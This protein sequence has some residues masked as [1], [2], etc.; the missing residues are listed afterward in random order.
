MSE[1]KQLKTS[2]GYFDVV[3]NVLVDENTFSLNQ[4]GKNNANWISNIFNPKVDAG[5]G[6][7]MF[8][9]FNSGFDKVNGKTIYAISESDSS[10][11]IPF[12]DRKND[13]LLKVVKDSSF[14]KVGYKK[15]VVKNPEN[16]KE[17]KQW[18]YEKFV[19]A[20][21]VVEFLQ[22]V[23]PLAT[24]QKVHIKG[25][26]KFS[27]N[28]GEVYRNFDLQTIYLLNGNEDEGKE[29]PLKLEFT[30][31]ILLKEGSI[32]R[33]DEDK[34]T[35]T[36]NAL[37]LNKSKG[38]YQTLPVNN[39]VKFNEEDKNAKLN[40]INK[41]LEAPE[42]KV[43]RVN[44]LGLF[45][46]GSSSGSVTYDDLPQEAKDLVDDGIY[47]MEEI[48]KIYAKQDFVNNLLIRKPVVKKLD[49][50]IKIDFDDDEYTLA[51]LEGKSADVDEEIDLDLGDNEENDLLKE[52]E[53]L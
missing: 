34:G 49:N 18:V 11:Q 26:I 24:T 36:V 21:D 27:A 46:V 6:Q 17:Y 53:D 30:Q 3:A 7:S 31:N 10:L 12:A 29:L 4:V 43:R 22:R 28:N 19:D 47:S 25:K 2:T 38:E 23:M 32:D 41:Y 39:L 40:M 51:D 42:G 8:M 45:E 16:G 20:Y 14:I 13:A 1:E 5:N 50:S 35:I 33:K 52:L 15:E 37:I 44:V 9:K 48:Q